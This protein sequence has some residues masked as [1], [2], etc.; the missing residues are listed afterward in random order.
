MWIN[1][2]R[3]TYCGFDAVEDKSLTPSKFTIYTRSGLKLP[4]NSLVKKMLEVFQSQSQAVPGTPAMPIVEVEYGRLQSLYSTKMKECPGDEEDEDDP[5]TLSFRQVYTL[6]FPSHSHRGTS[7][8]NCPFQ[9]EGAFTSLSAALIFAF[10]A[11]VTEFFL[12]RV[13]R[14]RQPLRRKASIIVTRHGINAIS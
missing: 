8:L 7:Q 5:F 11:F 13:K 3:D 12:A 1:S 14:C 2:L 4:V 10:L 9:I 6:C